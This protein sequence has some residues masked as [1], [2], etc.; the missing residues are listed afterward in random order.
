MFKEKGSHDIADALLSLKHAVVHP[1]FGGPLSPL[2]PPPPPPSMPHLGCGQGMNGGVMNP[3]TPTGFSYT[4]SHNSPMFHNAYGTPAPQYSQYTDQGQTAP[5]QPLPQASVH[6]PAMSVNVSMSMNV[7]MPPSLG[8]GQYNN[9]SSQQWP[10]QPP[11]PPL[12]QYHSSGQNQAPP[13]S[14]QYGG[15]TPTSNYGPSYGFPG[16]YRTLCDGRGGFYCKHL[17]NFKD[18]AR[19]CSI[20]HI[21]RKF[22]PER[23]PPCP[24]EIDPSS[25]KTN[26]C[27][28]CGKTY[29]RPS[30]LKTHLRTHSGEKPY[31]CCTCSKS[32]SQV[33]GR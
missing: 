25:L 7:G 5:G 31:K 29:A 19:F 1:Q 18:D 24:P 32:F 3:Q 4:V 14:N 2:S 26:L 17:D 11:T 22:I 16:E 6:F 13:M 9:L 10:T 12:G 15:Y 28:I 8:G 27:R 33:S 23:T 21:K 30:T 20:G